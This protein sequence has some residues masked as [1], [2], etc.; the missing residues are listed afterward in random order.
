[1]EA[2]HKKDII[3]KVSAVGIIILG[4]AV[5][6]IYLGVRTDALQ[7]AWQGGK[8]SALPPSLH[9]MGRKRGKIRNQPAVKKEAK[10][11]DTVS[12]ESDSTSKTNANTAC[13]STVGV[14]A[15]DEAA[16]KL[17]EKTSKGKREKKIEGTNT[18]VLGLNGK[19][20][21]E[22]KSEKTEDEHALDRQ[23][24]SD[25]TICGS[26]DLL[27]APMLDERKPPLSIEEEKRK[28]DLAKQAV[29]IAEKEYEKEVACLEELGRA[30]ELSQSIFQNKNK[31]FAR[32]EASYIESK[33]EYDSVY[34]ELSSI[35]QEVNK[36]CTSP[37]NAQI[38]PTIRL[39]CSS[40]IKS[41]GVLL[42]EIKELSNILETEKEKNKPRLKCIEKMQKTV[43][44]S[45]EDSARYYSSV[46]DMEKNLIIILEYTLEMYKKIYEKEKLQLFVREK[47]AEYFKKNNEG[48]ESEALNK[49]LEGHTKH[50]ESLERFIRKSSDICNLQK[51]VISGAIER[52][53][54]YIAYDAAE[55]KYAEQKE[56][57]SVKSDALTRAEEV[58]ERHNSR[59]YSS[60]S[61]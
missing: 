16:E 10:K 45:R 58:L 26:S 43:Y 11:A 32:V 41:S 60:A 13:V 33:W 14:S 20:I 28:R 38:A 55:S 48:K 24:T 51:D 52:H 56:V 23:E 5:F 53:E 22:R 6:G 30:A 49:I 21:E 36:Y 18:G 29:D 8:K 40:E 4:L 1:M 7:N 27:D 59:I 25:A 2:M 46:V 15:D 44:N 57:V 50:I 61:S 42:K 54:A 34:E 39:E 19:E 12:S 9:S 37:I 31:E 3:A 35:T 17:K 47:E